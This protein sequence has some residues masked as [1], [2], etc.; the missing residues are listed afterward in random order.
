M[1]Y[2]ELISRSNSAFLEIPKWNPY[3]KKVLQDVI[4]MTDI[5]SYGIGIVTH[6]EHI[7]GDK[8]KFCD[9]ETIVKISL[10]WLSPQEI[11]TLEKRLELLYEIM[12]QES[13]VLNKGVL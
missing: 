5:Y 3:I 2:V 9:F 11:E 12:D 4:E 1:Y 10:N 8:M 6:G 13:K 7:E